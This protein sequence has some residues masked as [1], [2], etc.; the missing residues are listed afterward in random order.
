M[1][2]S[3]KVEHRKEQR[4]LYRT[5]VRQVLLMADY[6]QHK[7]FDIYT[8]AAQFYNQLNEKYP[9]KYDLRKTVEFRRWKM[10]VM[11]QSQKTRKLPKPAHVNI[12]T[13]IQ[14]HPQSIITIIHEDQPPSPDSSEQTEQPETPHE[15]QPP[16]PDSSEQTEQPETP[17]EDQPPSP[18]SSEQT[19]QPETPHEGQPPSPDPNE[20]PETPREDQSSSPVELR[21]GK[22]TYTDNMQ[23]RIPLL[24]SPPKH[25]AVIV[26]TLQT[27]TEE[28][29]Q[30]GTVLE[31]SLYEELA[32]EVVE[33]IIS[34]LRA[35]LDLQ[36]IM[37][38]IEQQL[39][40]EQLGMDIDIPEHDLLEIELE[41]W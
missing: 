41:N 24:T 3:E 9:T 21:L 33:K 37:T 4:R 20:Q 14:I 25:P 28:T 38:S 34:E 11:G 8:E 27:V 18:D 31:P 35:E 6:I 5:R 22:H 17:H 32:P 29:L 40:F 26:E 2:E 39:E 19:E 12:E 13:P 1:A 10:T 16:S 15:D 30:E 7:Y 23:L 36:D